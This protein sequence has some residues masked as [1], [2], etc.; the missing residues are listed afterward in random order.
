ME[1][2]EKLLTA[3]DGAALVWGSLAL[4]FILVAGRW[5]TLYS[6]HDLKDPLGMVEWSFTDSWAS[7]LTAVGALLG[8]VLAISG[9]IPEDAEPL[10]SNALTG[11]NLFFGALVVIAPLVFS[12]VQRVVSPPHANDEGPRYKGFVWGF[13]MAC[14]FTLWGVLGELGTLFVLLREVEAGFLPESVTSL[15]GGVL[16]VAIVAVSVYSWIRIKGTITWKPDVADFIGADT[17]PRKW[18]LL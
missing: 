5:L 7:T 3:G 14:F 9:I 1:A 13:L 10:A 2:I 11:L 16:A 12:A 17:R 4:S 8:T 18:R 15:F 6:T